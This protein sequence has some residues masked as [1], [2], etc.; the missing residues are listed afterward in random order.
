MCLRRGTSC[1]RWGLLARET[2]KYERYSTGRNWQS[3]TRAHLL[4]A[5]RLYL[6]DASG[7]SSSS[8]RTIAT[9]VGMSAVLE[10]GM[11]RLT[12]QS[13]NGHALTEQPG[14]GILLDAQQAVE[15]E[16]RAH[17]SR[18]SAKMPRLRCARMVRR[19]LTVKPR[20]GSL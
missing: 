8:R 19:S 16:H 7:H 14:A 3:S 5:G 18:A 17:H 2:S 13:C 20:A 15:S 12:P 1:L 4:S 10:K 11:A 9:A 6:H